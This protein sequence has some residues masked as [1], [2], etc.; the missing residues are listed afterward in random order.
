MMS[1]AIKGKCL[2]M[3][4]EKE[5]WMREKEGLLHV[6]EID[7]KQGGKKRKADPAR[8]VKSYGRPAAGQNMTDPNELRPAPVLLLTVKYLL[9]EIA[10]RTDVDWI[11]VY[12]FIFDRLR[13]VRQDVVIQRISPISSISIYEPIVRFLLFSSHRL[14]DRKLTEFDPM[15]NDHHLLECIKHVLALYDDLERQRPTDDFDLDICMENLSLTDHRPEMEAIYI[16]LQIGDVGALNRGLKLPPQI[17][18][19]WLVQS[20]LKVSFA[21][22]LNNYARAFRLTQKLPPM[23]M[24]AAVRNL[25]ALRKTTWKIMCNAYNSKV[26]TYPGIKLQELLLY[27]DIKKVKDDCQNYGQIFMEDTQNIQFQKVNFKE[28]D[29]LTTPEC[30]YPQKTLHSF[31]PNILLQ[32]M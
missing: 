17:R 31:L 25:Q 14:C 24:F 9:S 16:L 13:A 5:R 19:S 18:Q 8:T 32:S 26:L 2:L 3:C 6:F 4:P 1:D 23:L 21:W 20:A 28:P 27:M 10:T 15:I 7:P 30:L 29:K 22:Y 12:D 11:T